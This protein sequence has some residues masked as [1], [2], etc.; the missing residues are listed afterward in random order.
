MELSLVEPFW[1][2]IKSRSRAQFK[3]VAVQTEFK[4]ALDQ[5]ASAH[6]DQRL[7]H[8]CRPSSLRALVSAGAAAQA[9]AM[10]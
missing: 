1:S 3:A 9:Q 5:R 4:A 10:P 2:P 6:W 7:L 8:R